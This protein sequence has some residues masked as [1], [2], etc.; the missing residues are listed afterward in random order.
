MELTMWPHEFEDLMYELRSLKKELSGFRE[1]VFVPLSEIAK[2]LSNLNDA[3]RSL[4][5]MVERGAGDGK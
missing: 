1:E 2:Q 3:A 4:I 5:R